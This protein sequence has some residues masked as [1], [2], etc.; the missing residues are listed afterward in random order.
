MP[1]SSPSDLAKERHL[2][3]LRTPFGAEGF[4]EEY[5]AAIAKTASSDCRAPL[6]GLGTVLVLAATPLA[7]DVGATSPK[8]RV[9][10][11]D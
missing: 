2:I 10:S 4:K 9:E 7:N 5:D 11:G 6:A 8:L 1:E 3:R